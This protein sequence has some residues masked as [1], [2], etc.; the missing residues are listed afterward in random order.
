MTGPALTTAERVPSATAQ[1]S[2]N[3][4]SSVNDWPRITK[5]S[6]Y[7][8]TG[9]PTIP[10]SQYTSTAA[11]A[12]CAAHRRAARRSQRTMRDSPRRYRAD[13]VDGADRQPADHRS[14]QQDVRP[15]QPAGGR[16]VD[17]PQVERL[18]VVLWVGEVGA[19]M[20]D[21]GAAIPQVRQPERE[22]REGQ[23]GVDAAPGRR[24]AVQRLVL[25][26]HV[27]TTEQSKDCHGNR[28]G[29]FPCSRTTASHAT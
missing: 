7:S 1:C 24:M 5:P 22:W 23:C 14:G 6:R 11:A 29:Q 10:N 4:R 16:P 18:G 2:T 12:R 15:L 25:Q 19:V 21:V 8:H 3:E 17:R 28:P 27:E 26:R 13:A 20:D 9:K